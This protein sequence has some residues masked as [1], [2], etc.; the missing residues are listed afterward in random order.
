MSWR[1]RLQSASLSGIACFVSDSSATGGRRQEVHE[2]PGR[3]VPWVE[4]M[5]RKVRTLD[6]T[7]YVLGDDYQQARDALIARMEQAGEATFNHPRWGTLKVLPADYS[8]HESTAQGGYAQIALK[9]YEPGIKKFPSQTVDTAA[10]VNKAGAS[11]LSAAKSRFSKV[12]SVVAKASHVATWA[13]G[14]VRAVADTLR[15][16]NG[17][18]QTVLAPIEDLSRS[19]DDLYQQAANLVG[20]PGTLASTFGL[21][22]GSVVGGSTTLSGI[23]RHHHELITSAATLPALPAIDTA[24]HRQ[25]RSNDAAL[26]QLV[27]VQGVVA[28]VQGVVALSPVGAAAGSSPFTSYDHAIEVR[29]E[30]LQVLDSLLDEV[31]DATYIALSD[32]R[33]AFIR[34]IEAHGV[35]LQ[36]VER[37]S[38]QRP[39]P[40]LA[41]AY[42]LYG[43]IGRSDDL[44]R[45]NGVRHPMRIPDGTLEILKR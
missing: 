21:L 25:I 12:F 6:I 11:V 1:D 37:F 16:V 19:I 32:L 39:L 3:D 38:L 45:R 10:L 43:D 34:H 13:A 5:G 2:Y 31:D 44:V 14:K 23:S 17:M 7:V 35:N 33:T 29:T 42:R 40:A 4:D 28:A 41:L 30:W 22:I 26:Q 20:L 24:S 27:K 15:R 36:R 9:F 8:L 18:V